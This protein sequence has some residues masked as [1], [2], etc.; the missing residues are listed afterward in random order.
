M[1]FMKGN[2]LYATTKL[3][4]NS[5][6]V[7]EFVHASFRNY[8]TVTKIGLLHI[9]IPGPRTLFLVIFPEL[10]QQDIGRNLCDVN[11]MTT[12]FSRQDC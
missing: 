10:M 12:P 8:C 2:S 11:T 1:R 7:Q 6:I 4:Y 5:P 3:V 9:R